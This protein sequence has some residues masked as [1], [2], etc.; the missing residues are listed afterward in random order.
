[1]TTDV[2]EAAGEC[3]SE[4]RG[5]KEEIHDVS[6]TDCCIVGCGPAGAMLG[7]LLA[8]QGIDVLVL[9]KHGDFIR[10]FRGD[11]IHPSTME[12]M[13]EL[14]LA[15]GLLRV[16]HT[17]VPDLRIQTPEWSATATDFRQLKT[18]FPYITFMPQ[19]DFLDFV[20]QEARR[21]PGF[22]LKVNA[23]VKKII[24]K[25]GVIRGVCYEAPDGA[26]EVRALLTVA[27]DGRSSRVREQAGLKVIDTAP[28]ID[29]LW[30]RLS[31]RENDP[32]ALDLRIGG[33][34]VSILINRGDYWQVAYVIP[35]GADQEV[36][37]A[38]LETFRKSIGDAVPELADRVDELQDWDQVKLLSVQANRLKR[39]YRPGLLCIGDAA[40]AMSPIGGVGINLAIQDAVAAANKLDR[41]LKA[42]RPDLSALA[43]VQRRREWPTRFIQTLQSLLQ[44]QVA[45]PAIGSGSAPSFPASARKLLRRRVL[46]RIPA[47]IIAFGI[48][49]GHIE[50]RNSST[51][52][53]AH[54]IQSGA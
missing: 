15:E 13:D 22:H 38:G 17:K 9:E 28:P 19:W 31:R 49:P 23:E 11:T 43:T 5:P 7:L 2:R 30:F 52:T 44:R 26:H 6:C 16:K 50:R 53:P 36:R 51:R 8:R 41:P 32:S 47:R 48:W 54:R 20:V 12:I 10:D 3:S 14:D 29:V 1:M 27:A 4:A 33:G 37:A 39:W 46:R 18:R 21:Y 24:E 42:G 45:A 25:D 40:H 34:Y 35:K